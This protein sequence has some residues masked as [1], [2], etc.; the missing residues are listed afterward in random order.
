MLEEETKEEEEEELEEEE[1]ELEEEEEEFE[2][3]C[4]APFLLFK[5][6]RVASSV[7]TGGGLWSCFL[8]FVGGV[9]FL[10]GEEGGDER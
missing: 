1:E 7:L 6:R 3:D 5:D 4:F 9:F 8:F 10:E 2:E